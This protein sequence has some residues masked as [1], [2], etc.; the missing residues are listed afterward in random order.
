MIDLTTESPLSLTEAAK[1]LPSLGGRR[2][3]VS[4][5][6]RWA[7]RGLRGVKLEYSRL[8]HRVVT[9]REALNRFAQR[10]AEA[11][12]AEDSSPIE[13]QAARWQQPLITGKPRSAKRR[14]EDVARAR[15]ELSEAGI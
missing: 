11:D 5:L 10:L 3:H 14:A 8:G 12:A 13:R 6:W 2:L 15:R 4:T 7:R 1:V 9:S